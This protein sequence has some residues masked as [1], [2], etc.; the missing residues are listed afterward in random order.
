MKLKDEAVG[1]LAAG[2]VGTVIGFPLD[3]IKVRC[4][5]CSIFSGVMYIILTFLWIILSII[6]SII[7]YQTRMQT[8]NNYI[9]RQ[10]ILRIGTDIIKN[11]GM[12]A[13]Y[14]GLIPPL[15]SLSLLN[16]INFSSYS[17]IREKFGARHQWDYRNALAGLSVGPIA[18]SISTIEG[19]VK[20]QMQLD[21]VNKLG[22]GVRYKNSF[23]CLAKLVRA[24]SMFALYHGHLVNT[25]RECVFLGSYFFLYEGLKTSFI[26]NFDMNA[27][28]SV[29]IAGGISGAL[30]WF[31]SFPLDCIRAGVQS[32]DLSM[33]NANRRRGIAVA[34]NLYQ[35]KGFMGLYAG[36]TPSIIRAFLVSGSR[37]SAYES[38][39]WLLKELYSNNIS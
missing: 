24:N 33:K 36:I 28:V 8:G 5:V 15:V 12:F 39:L 17:I 18:S 37:F 32:Q 29:P 22:G 20:T 26:Y 4:A 6:F 10:S 3:L 25:F 19:V 11:E 35:T 7:L 14:K 34:M 30:S 2:I 23:D 9:R 1:G 31:V 21:N 16:T 38:A 27:K 13:L